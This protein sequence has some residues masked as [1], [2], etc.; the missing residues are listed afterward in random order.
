MLEQEQRFKQNQE[1]VLPEPEISSKQLTQALGR[2]IS[3][4][5]EKNPYSNNYLPI[6]GDEKARITYPLFIISNIKSQI[7][8]EGFLRK[9]TEI[10]KKIEHQLK[11]E[12]IK[13]LPVKLQILLDAGDDNLYTLT[14]VYYTVDLL[15]YLDIMNISYVYYKEKGKFTTD[16][17]IDT[18][19]Y[20]K[21][22]DIIAPSDDDLIPVELA[23]KHK[24]Q[25][26]V[27]DDDIL[28]KVVCDNELDKALFNLNESYEVTP[29][30][31]T[32]TTNES[33]NNQKDPDDQESY[34]PT[35]ED[36]TQEDEEENDE[37]DKDEDY[38]YDDYIQW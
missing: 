1:A 28:D 15:N 11:F 29:T 35:N 38:D 2:D 8:I 20:E 5:F 33:D 26:A 21:W 10:N 22:N 6:N 3:E 7:L 14:N 37:D 25:V 27:S 19:D 32:V 4:E 12:Q 17:Y 16:V 36:I 9:C 13:I 34:L 31:E 18:D 24:P 30:K 23:D